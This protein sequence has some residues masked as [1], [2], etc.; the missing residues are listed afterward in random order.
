MTTPLFLK[1]LGGVSISE[2]L[3][4]FGSWSEFFFRH[5]AN[6]IM[7]LIGEFTFLRDI[8]I[9]VRYLTNESVRRLNL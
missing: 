4:R 2:K 7:S 6:E 3:N 9:F 8:R 1:I 5:K